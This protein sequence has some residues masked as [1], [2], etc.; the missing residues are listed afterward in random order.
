MKPEHCPQCAQCKKR[1]APTYVTHEVKVETMNA[2]GGIDTK[3]VAERDP[4]TIEGFGY[5]AR[6]KFCSLRCGYEWA[7]VR[8]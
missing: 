6:G 7:M 4:N 8:A 3:T 5:H 2:L 1:L